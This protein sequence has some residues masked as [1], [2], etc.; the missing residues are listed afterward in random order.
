[1]NNL[2][3]SF[4]PKTVQD[5]INLYNNGQLNLNPSFQ[6]DS[7][8]RE[9][10]RSK[11]I[12]SILIGYPLPSIF[13]YKKNEQ[14]NI[15]YEVI[16]GKQRIESI[17]MF[18]GEIPR[19]R[20]KAA[21]QS[22]EGNEKVDWPRL[23]AKKSQHK[24]TDYNLQVVEVEGDLSSIIDLFVK[25]NSTGKALTGAEKRHA[26]YYK[27]EL[28][29]KANQI[30]NKYQK[31]FREANIISSNQMSR[32]KHIELVCE[33]IIAS[34]TRDVSNK[35]T[36]L[37]KVMSNDSIK[38]Q[39][40]IKATA[41]SQRALNRLNR[42]FPKLKETRFSQTSDFYSLAVLIQEFECNNLIL[43]DR[44]RNQL[45]WEML[46]AFSTGVDKVREAQKRIEG[47]EPEQQLYRDYLIT[48]RENTDE[49]NQRR[50]RQQILRD[51][52][53]PIFQVKDSDRFFTKEQRRILWNTTEN[54]KCETCHKK[55]TWNNFTID[56]I[57]P[58]SKG[59]RT[60]L[61]NAALMCREHN[62][63]KGNRSSKEA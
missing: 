23:K 32:M 43:N 41:I 37:D 48:V 20:F 22:E 17:F 61:D 12:E 18:T 5:L 27:S 52:L 36:V 59:G 49:I 6:R 14:G 58:H 15:T 9:R 11:L 38:G 33:L 10:D 40:L 55:L 7:V 3:F 57:D 25:I 39:S 2:K 26:K 29:K 51:L 54:P 42:M 34:H 62:S 24:I 53:E 1:M 8:W 19:K 45:A 44:K 30:A 47:T 63:A 28:L 35:K 4:Y 31:Y 50:K 60:R 56:H 21:N 16:D 46:K 13:L